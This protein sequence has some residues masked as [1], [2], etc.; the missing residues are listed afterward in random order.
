MLRLAKKYGCYGVRKMTELLPVESWRVNRK[1]VD[2]LGLEEGLKLPERH[3][4]RK[5]EYIRSNNGPECIAAEST[6]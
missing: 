5:L 3:K 1:R 4:K 6:A 2:R